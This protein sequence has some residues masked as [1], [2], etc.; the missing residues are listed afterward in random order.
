MSCVRIRAFGKYPRNV[1]NNREYKWGHSN[2]VWLIF[3]VCLTTFGT[4]WRMQL[5]VGLGRVFAEFNWKRKTTFNVFG[6]IPCAEILNETKR[7]NMEPVGWA[8]AFYL[9]CF[10]TGHK[11]IYFL[12]RSGSCHPKDDWMH[13][14]TVRQNTIFLHCFVQIFCHRNKKSNQYRKTK[15]T[16]FEC[17][18]DELKD[19]VMEKKNNNNT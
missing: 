17:V 8:P 16:A 14:K 19:L 5:W 9:F 12:M 4:A 13:L 18:K 11:R 15:P 2:S 10:M 7:G 3:C 6:T 1:L